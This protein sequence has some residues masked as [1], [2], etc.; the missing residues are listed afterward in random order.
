MHRDIKPTNV[1]ISIDGEV[2]IVD[3]GVAK[4]AGRVEGQG[5]LTGTIAYMSPEQA[6]RIRSIIT[7]TSSR[8]GWSST[9][10]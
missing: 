5:Q 7:P 6:E 4:L 10:C 9:S 1:L 2:K 8:P 3:F